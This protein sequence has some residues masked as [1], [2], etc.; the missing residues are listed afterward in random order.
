MLE[1]TNS[2]VDHLDNK[3]CYNL[4]YFTASWCGPCKRISPAMDEISQ[5]LDLD[6]NDIIHMLDIYKVDLDDNEELVRKLDVRSVPTFFLYY[7][8]T[9]INKCSGAN[10]SKVKEL[11]TSNI[12]NKSNDLNNE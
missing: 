4:L 11:I 7:Q 2:N 5:G 3:E 9:Y 12:K 1:I 8:K 10:I 6:T